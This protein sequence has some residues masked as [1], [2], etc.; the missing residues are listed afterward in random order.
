MVKEEHA[1]EGREKSGYGKERKSGQCSLRATKLELRGPKMK[2]SKLC[3]RVIIIK[4]D[5]SCTDGK[6]LISYFDA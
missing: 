5:S 3:Y 6:Q 1:G 4:V 2:C